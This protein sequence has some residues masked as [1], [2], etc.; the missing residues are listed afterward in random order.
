[1]SD[2]SS[3]GAKKLTKQP[4]ND[5]PEVMGQLSLITG[6]SNEISTPPKSLTN[7]PVDVLE[8]IIQKVKSYKSELILRKVCKSLRDF[9]DK[10]PPTL[11]GVQIDYGPDSIVCAYNLDCVHYDS[12]HKNS[13][14]NCSSRLKC[15]AMVSDDYEKI[16]FDDI[17]FSLKNPKLQL[18]VLSVHFDDQNA[19]QY[20]KLREILDSI[21]HQ[22]SSESCN[23][24]I[25]RPSEYRSILP[26]LKPGV[27]EKITVRYK[28]Q[29][30]DSGGKDT[31]LETLKEVSLLEQ[32]KKAEELDFLDFGY[33]KFPME[34]AK[35]FKVFKF[36]EGAFDI[37][38]LNG[39][40]DFVL[41]MEN[42]EYCVIQAFIPLYEDEFRYIWKRVGVPVAGNERTK[43][44]SHYSIPNTDE[45]LEFM[46]FIH[47]NVVTIEKKSISQVMEE[48][49]AENSKN[50]SK[51][52]LSD[53]PANV[54]G[55]IIEK[56][57]YIEQ[58]ILRKVS[59]SLRALVDEQKPNLARL[60]VSSDPGFIQCNYND[61]TKYYAEPDCDAIAMDYG[62]ESEEVVWS[63]E[64]E[65]IAFNDLA[66]TLKNPKLQLESLSV[67]F[68]DFSDDEDGEC[69]AWIQYEKFCDMLS[70]IDHLVSV[71]EYNL[72]INC[73]EKTYSILPYLK[74]GV[75]EKI[76]VRYR[77]H[78]DEDDYGT[79]LD[80]LEE[81]ISLCEQWK[82]TKELELS[83]VGFDSFPM[84]YAKHFKRFVFNE[85]EVDSHLLFRFRNYLSK[86]DNFEFCLIKTDVS[87]SRDVLQ[88]LCG[89]VGIPAA[90][91]ERT[92]YVSHYRIP[93]SDD[94]LE[95]MFFMCPSTVTIEKK[96]T[97]K[98][99]SDETLAPPKSFSNMP[100][101]VVGLIIRKLDY[102]QQLKLRKV[103]KSLRTLVDKQTPSCKS[104]KVDF[105]DGYVNIV[106]DKYFVTYTD[107]IDDDD[108]GSGTIDVV[109]EDYEK[110]A[111]ND[112][113][114]TL[115]NPKLQL[116]EFKT[117]GNG[118]IEEKDLK[119]YYNEIQRVFEPLNH[120]LFVKKV[121]LYVLSPSNLLSILPYLRPGF[122]ENIRLQLHDGRNDNMRMDS[123]GMDQ[124][125]L[126]EQWKQP[127]ELELW[128]YFDM[129]PM[130][131]ATHFKRFQIIENKINGEK[132]IRIKDYLSKLD[133]FEQCTLHSFKAIVGPDSIIRQLGASV[134]SNTTEKIFH[135]P[136]PDSDS[137]FEIKWPKEDFT[138]RFDITKKKRD[139]H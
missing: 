89:T 4:N 138:I 88:L 120:Q 7:I 118:Y 104:I 61:E 133:N 33:R 56:S 123:T 103:S 64:Y 62:E 128:N 109:R 105:G 68:E 85:D 37:N 102:R 78:E 22:L 126:L 65:D 15:R 87:F 97:N 131:Y 46:F 38:K 132:F 12:P 21:E 2:T 53:M 75:L 125:A 101:D 90:R 96:K 16:A 54:L 1:M 28:T 20:D 9:I 92:E 83:E 18:T 57:D 27:L 43:Y 121:G 106:F 8:L 59:M 108:S 79:A 77:N 35:H 124:V 91:K 100:A 49:A 112:L 94:Y 117:S 47:G 41:T 70:S 139:S 80:T 23:I 114:S 39:Y 72:D 81:E 95:F 93:D 115:K 34:Y 113:A 58:L 60:E 84:E 111:F 130:E 11:V 63:E 45:I 76:T 136:I 82:Q 5:P 137:Y 66:L 17:A 122:L 129:F 119:E 116:E 31:A 32:W 3:D 73:P 98:A 69:K 107:E 74:P 26:Y 135:H 71:K 24:E 127:E 40:R 13:V 50:S 10:R 14:K 110:I 55:L 25:A 51:P 52:S 36:K 99:D 19:S 86:L 44:V 134:S 6:D 48:I 30:D 67:E 42:F 29:G